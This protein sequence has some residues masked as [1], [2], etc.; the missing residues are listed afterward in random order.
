[1]AQVIVVNMALLVTAAA[2]AVGTLLQIHSLLLHKEPSE[3]LHMSSLHPIYGFEVRG[4]WHF[5]HGIS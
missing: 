1:M 2:A 4:L 3:F 5:C